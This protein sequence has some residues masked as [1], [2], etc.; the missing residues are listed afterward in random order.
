[1]EKKN[2]MT[3]QKAKR[4]RYQLNTNLIEIISDV[5]MV[6]NDNGPLYY[7][8]VIYAN[9]RIEFSSLLTPTIDKMRYLLFDESAKNNYIYITDD[10]LET[11]GG[12]L[13]IS[14]QTPN[15]T[16]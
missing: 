9:S 14:I 1:M 4:I 16:L 5:Y 10:F 3:M 2:T 11:L 13:R 8:Y 6:A 12:E 7:F 15:L